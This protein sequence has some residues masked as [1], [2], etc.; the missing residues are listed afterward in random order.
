MTE[1]TLTVTVCDE[2][3]FLVASWNEPDG[4][5]GITTQARD[6]QELQDN[7]RETVS[8]HF[9]PGNAPEQ[10]RLVTQGSELDREELDLDEALEESRREEGWPAKEV[11]EE[12]RA[13]YRIP[14]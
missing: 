2:S 11:F 12:L 8:V 4:N 9:D 6:L 5:G 3:G 10:I 13:R 7:V 1:I 14:R